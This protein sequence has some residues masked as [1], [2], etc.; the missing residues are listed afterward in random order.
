MPYFILIRLS[1]CLFGLGALKDARKACITNRF[2]FQKN[3]SQATTTIVSDDDTEVDKRDSRCYNS[4]TDFNQT[5]TLYFTGG[6]R[7]WLHFTR[8]SV[9][10]GD[11]SQEKWQLFKIDFAFKIDEDFP[12]AKRKCF[13]C[14]RALA[15]RKEGSKRFLANSSVSVR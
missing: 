12:G 1:R 4:S 2:L 14:S 9:I 6:R 13:G 5:L 3:G 15:G 10:T 11:K 8:D 7:L